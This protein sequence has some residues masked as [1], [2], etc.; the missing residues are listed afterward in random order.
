M[1]LRLNRHKGPKEA[2]LIYHKL[3]SNI[4]ARPI[5]S[6]R[7]GLATA[8]LDEN[9]LQIKPMLMKRRPTP[10]LQQHVKHR[11]TSPCP[12]RRPERVSQ[13][14]GGRPMPEKSK[15]CVT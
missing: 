1:S 14:Q 8:K 4:K 7:N 5:F 11:G 12:A 2:P 15:A 10:A 6:G 3:Q 13:R 9:T